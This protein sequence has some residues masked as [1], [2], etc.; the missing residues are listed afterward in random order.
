[1][2]GYN[3]ARAK[4]GWEATQTFSGG[5]TVTSYF[6]KEQLQKISTDRGSATILMG[7]EF[8]LVAVRE[9]VEKASEGDLVLLKT[10]CITEDEGNR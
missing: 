3:N 9:I 7:A 6:G 10:I 5:L 1:M 8:P 2:P 4:T